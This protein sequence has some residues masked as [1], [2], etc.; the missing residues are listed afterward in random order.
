VAPIPRGGTIAVTGAAGFV[1]GWVVRLL[2]DKGYRV[3]ACV[4][5]AADPGR[6]EFLREMPGHA[7]GRLTLHSADLDQPGCFDDIFSG[8]HG[9]MHVSHVSTYDDQEYLKGVCDHVIDSINASRSV[10]R[11][12]LTSST[13]AII[14]EADITELVRRPVLYEDR[15]PD[16]ANPKRTAERGQGYSMGKALAERVFAEAAAASG[17]WD[18]ITCCPGDNLGPVQSRH[19][20]DGGPWQSLVAE[21]LQ[22]RCTQTGAYRPWMPVDVRDDAE[23]H[24]RLAEST[25]VHNGERYIAWSA[26]RFDVEEICASIDRVL[27]ELGHATAELIDPFADRIRQR[28]PEL[29]ATWA[30][31]DLRNDRIKAVTGVEFRPFD[32]TLR[33]CV[34]SLLT[35]GGV[36]P[37]VR[38]GFGA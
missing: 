7:S 35:I 2:L 34:E 10:S 12:V 22:G 15:H 26:E 4:R 21:M 3:R 6:C 9:V 20:K 31:C 5:D 37:L 17:S 18:S 8:C 30:G 29:R 11:V 32:Q 33:D 27:P 28:E 25:E 19:Q 24:I 16:E 38:E 13:A 14:S 36:Q 1:G 23:C